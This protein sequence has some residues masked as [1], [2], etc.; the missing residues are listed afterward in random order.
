VVIVV[1][2]VLALVCKFT[3]GTKNLFAKHDGNLGECF[4]GEESPIQGHALW[5]AL[6]AVMFLCMF[7]FFRYMGGRSRSVFPWLRDA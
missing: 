2:G 5:H 6:S 7:E 4:W 1:V 3:D